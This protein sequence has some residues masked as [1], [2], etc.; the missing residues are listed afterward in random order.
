MKKIRRKIISG[1]VLAFCAVFTVTAGARISGKVKNEAVT[2]S[3]AVNDTPPVIVLDAG[4]G[5]S[6]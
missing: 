1:G 3:A 6:S 4:H 2:V 5:A